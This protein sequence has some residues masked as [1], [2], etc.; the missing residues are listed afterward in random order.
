MNKDKV[1]SVGKGLTQVEIARHVVAALVAATCMTTW[2]RPQDP[3]VLVRLAVAAYIM[4]LCTSLGVAYL[5]RGYLIFQA[6]M[7]YAFY[8]W[9]RWTLLD[10]FQGSLEKMF[11]PIACVTWGLVVVYF[12]SRLV[13]PRAH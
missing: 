3:Y 4:S 12:F 7:Y 11:Q 2:A 13:L 1:P 8:L 6:A 10:R 9:A 5:G